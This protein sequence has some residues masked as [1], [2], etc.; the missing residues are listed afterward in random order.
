MNEFKD[1]LDS[2]EMER[3]KKLINELRELAVQGQI[4]T[5][6]TIKADTIRAKAAETQSASLNLFQ[7]VS[8]LLP[9]ESCLVL[10]PFQVYEKRAAENA[11][12]PEQ[13]ASESEPPKEKKD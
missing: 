4:G 8:G 1:Q 12:A 5:D 13:P 9:V 2:A 7:K 6:P 11:A 10:T 3:L